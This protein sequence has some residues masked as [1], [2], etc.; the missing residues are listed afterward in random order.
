[1]KTDVDRGEGGRL[2]GHG[3]NGG[4]KV[5]LLSEKEQ[6]SELEEGPSLR[7]ASH[8]EGERRNNNK[9]KGIKPT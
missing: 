3:V 6:I 4:A 5:I 9:G 8:L 2:S 1:L 7:K